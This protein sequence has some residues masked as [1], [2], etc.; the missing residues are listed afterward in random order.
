MSKLIYNCSR[1]W[2]QKRRVI[3]IFYF[4]MSVFKRTAK[5]IYNDSPEVFSSTEWFLSSKR[6]Q[7]KLYNGSQIVLISNFRMFIFEKKQNENIPIVKWEKLMFK[8]LSTV[9][10]WIECNVLLKI[11]SSPNFWRIWKNKSFLLKK[12]IYK[13]RLHLFE[14]DWGVFYNCFLLFVTNI[15]ASFP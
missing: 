13:N 12:N 2:K 9:Y 10:K 7:R 8:P 14:V 1:I 4:M 6:Q 11:F 3:L 15:F 5:E